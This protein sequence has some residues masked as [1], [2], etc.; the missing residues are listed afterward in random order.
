MSVCFSN[1]QTPG[2]NSMYKGFIGNTLQVGKA[3]NLQY[4]LDTR[5][6]KKKKKKEEGKEGFEYGGPPISVQFWG[7]WV[8]PAYRRDP[9]QI[10]LLCSVTGWELPR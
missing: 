10:S 9:T 4:Y 5:A 3:L 6:N 1:K 8:M 2:W 7:V